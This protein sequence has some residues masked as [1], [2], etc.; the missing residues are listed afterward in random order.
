MEIMKP[1]RPWFAALLTL[2]TPGL[3]HLYAGYPLAAV[4]AHIAAFMLM[5]LMIT[6]W[7]FIP[8]APANI[9]LGL[10]AFPLLYLAIPTH[11][12]ILARRGKTDYRLKR[13]NRWYVYLGVCIITRLII[14]PQLQHCLQSNLEA[15]RIPSPAMEPT[16]AVGD[17]LYAVKNA[18]ANE[19]VVNGDVVIFH[20]IEEPELKV[21]KRVVGLPGD[22]VAMEHGKLLRNGRELI[23]KYVVHRELDRSEDAKQRAKM[24]AWQV[25]HTVGVD[26]ATYRPDLQDWGPVV[27]PPDSFLNLGDNRDA[28]YDSR[29]Y[30]FVP[31]V[32][33]VGRPR[34]IYVSFDSGSIRWSRIGQQV[35]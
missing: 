1:R 10:V 6:A 33:L 8:I 9:L 11:A 12:A 3:G 18:W 23:E 26:T 35:K 30:G 25:L 14:Y 15:F 29:Y 20:S 32:N 27:V 4:L 13:Y 2:V 21:V 16:L 5:G 22:T 34:V 31:L 19:P 7:V 28:S 17:Y 24:R